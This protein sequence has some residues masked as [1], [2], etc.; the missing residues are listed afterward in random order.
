MIDKAPTFSTDTL[1]NVFTRME[2][3]VG[4]EARRHQEILRD[5]KE[6]LVDDEGNEIHTFRYEGTCY[7]LRDR[8]G[9]LYLATVTKKSGRAPMS[10]AEKAE[11]AAE[12]AAQKAHEAALE[13][14][15]DVELEEGERLV[16]AEIV[17]LPDAVYNEIAAQEDSEDVEVVGEDDILADAV[18]EAN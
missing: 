18:A 3:N 15:G 9:Q 4:S 12:R 8:K 1:G 13:E 10:E 11:R 14:A 16:E 6:Q 5:M 17:V 2:E 7:Q